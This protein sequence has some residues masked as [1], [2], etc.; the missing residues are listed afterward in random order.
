MT[1][2]MLAVATDHQ[3]PAVIKMLLD[4]GAEPS[5]KSKIG[6]SALDWGTESGTAARTPTAKGEH[7]GVRQRYRIGCGSPKVGPQGRRSK[8]T[9]AD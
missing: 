9:G 4:H 7:R 1:P 6:D 5:A 2:I 8:D 3:D